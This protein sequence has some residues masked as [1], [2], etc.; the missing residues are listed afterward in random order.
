[1]SDTNIRE[2][3]ALVIG[4][5]LAGL[6]SA[7]LLGELGYRTVLLERSSRLGGINTSFAGPDGSTFDMGMHVLDY[8]RSP[9]TTRLFSR[10]TGERLR[11]TLLERAIVLRGEIMPYAPLPAQMP[12]AIRALLPA[13]LRVDDLGTA[14]PTR[15][16]IARIYG[17]GYAALIFD[18]VLPSYRCEQ[19][20]RQLGVGEEHLLTNIYPWFFPRVERPVA[21]A[22]ESR[23]FHDRLRRGEPQYVLYP[24]E[25]GFAGFARAFAE[26]LDPR[27]VET[28][29]DIPDLHVEIGAG[30]HTVRWVRAQGRRLTA[31]HVFWAGHWGGLCKLLGLPWQDLA[32]DNL[33]LGSFTL[34]RPASSRY[35]EIIVGDPALHIDRISFPGRFAGTD[36]PQLQLEFAFPVADSD[37]TPNAE[38]WQRIWLAD[39]RRL[40]VLDDAHVVESFDFRHL[41]MHFNSYGAEG[42]PH[43]EADPG[44]LHEDSN[45]VPVAPSVLNRNLNSS[46]PRY[47]E[48]VLG[49]VTGTR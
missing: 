7:W 28:L 26:A 22:G 42:R 8:M 32:T 30:A 6:I 29:I 43:V 40:G 20:H 25:G 9:V 1:M 35:N 18:E 49:A 4:A 16:R 14:P 2:V 3:D 37:S 24:S 38:H 48:A 17:P 46:V 41:R 15:E 10:M 27:Y 34:N 23:R 13:D 36:A 44:L 39:L 45:I 33:L 31:P 21:D 12:A 19:R 5:N 47:L 11:R